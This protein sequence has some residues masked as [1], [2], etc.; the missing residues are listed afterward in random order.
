MLKTMSQQKK[1]DIYGKEVK[2]TGLLTLNQED[3]L[4]YGFATNITRKSIRLNPDQQ[5]QFRLSEVA[6]AMAKRFDIEQN[7]EEAT[8]ILRTK[9]TVGSPLKK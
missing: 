7:F 4:S 5:L 1:F 3:K 6:P 9:S 8:K 2:K